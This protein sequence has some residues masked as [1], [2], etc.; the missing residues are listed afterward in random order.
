HVRGRLDGAV[1]E[2]PQDDLGRRINQFHVPWV[3]RQIA[4]VASGEMLY[5]SNRFQVAAYKLSNGERVWQS[6]P[7][8]GPMQR[9]QEWGLI[10]MRPLIAGDRIY[11]RMLYSPSPLLVCLDKSSGKLVW[12]GESRENEFLV[13]DPVVVEGQLVALSVL[14]QP[15]QHGLLRYNVFDRRSGELEPVHEL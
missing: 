6:Q 10:P 8:P 5:V 2:R 15:D 9:A 14:I 11:V 3:D 7:P 4:T 1:G 13:S 12:V